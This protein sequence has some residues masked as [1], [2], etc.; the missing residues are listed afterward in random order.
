MSVCYNSACHKYAELNRKQHAAELRRDNATASS[1]RRK[2]MWISAELAVLRA[3]LTA[4]GMLRNVVLVNMCIGVGMF[5]WIFTVEFIDTS[6]PSVFWW[7]AELIVSMSVLLCSTAACF[8]TRDF[9]RKALSTRA[10]GTSSLP[11][12]I[13]FAIST[14]VA[15]RA[16]SSIDLPQD[17]RIHM[18]TSYWR[19]IQLIVLPCVK[20]SLLCI[21]LTSAAFSFTACL[22]LVDATLAAL[23]KA[24]K[25][26][27]SVLRRLQ[28]HE[29]ADMLDSWLPSDLAA[30]AMDFTEYGREVPDQQERQQNKAEYRK[31]GYGTYS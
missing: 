23:K 24:I 9:L 14:Y 10:Y 26:L 21:S 3:L 27:A 4:V 1:L 18:H 2:R 17:N 30:H 22:P 19:T 25:N 12:G 7:F 15:F 11:E 5:A 31:R 6:Y 28:F 13:L 20:Y 8:T 16:Y 29:F